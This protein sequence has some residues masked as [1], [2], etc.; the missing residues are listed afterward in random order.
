MSYW[1]TILRALH[2]I[3]F[4]I[5]LL[6]TGI[7]IYFSGLF[8]EIFERSIGSRL[9]TGRDAIWDAFFRDFYT[10]N[11]IS[12]LFGSDLS[13]HLILAPSISYSTSDVHNTFLDILNYYGLFFLFFF[14]FWYIFVS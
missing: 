7:F 11:D 8:S 12:I 5:L 4:Y 10:R 6:A 14:F 2:S 9:L 13:R 3:K 1:K